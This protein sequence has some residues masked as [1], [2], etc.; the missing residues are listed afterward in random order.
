M[1]SVRLLRNAL[2]NNPDRVLDI[3]V[4]HARHAIAFMGNG[5]QVTG[6][7]VKGPEVESPLYEHLQGAFEVVDFED[8]QYDLIWCSHTLEHVH[9]IQA[10]LLKAASLLKDGGMLYI[11][12]PTDSQSRF[13]IG[14]LTLWNPV[15]LMYNLICSGWNCK[16]ARWYTEYCT[17]G[18][19][20]KKEPEIDLSWRTGMP[21][22]MAGLNQYM[23]GN[24]RHEAGSWLA[25]NWHEET[26]PM[27]TDPPGVTIGLTET[28]LPPQVQLAFGPNPTLREGYERNKSN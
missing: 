16:D 17:I 5:A 12:V 19:C 15:L 9:N 25:N 3:G 10:F 1:R 7:D 22:E 28:N 6:V 20:I 24:I 14:H 4:G 13:H 21:D 8:R 26:R 27:V 2:R 18:L 11:A 23:P